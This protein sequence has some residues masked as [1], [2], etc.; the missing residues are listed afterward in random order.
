MA[1]K[2]RPD[3]IILDVMMPDMD[4]WQVL[5]TL[6]ADPLLNDI[7]VIMSSI[8]DHQNM[9]YALGAT[10]YLVKPVSRDQ[11][12]HILSRYEN[13]D[14]DKRLVMV[15]EDDLVIRELMAEMLKSA[16]WRV[17]KAENGQ[18]ALEHVEDKLPALI[19]LDLLMP[20]MDGYEFVEKLRE[21]PA[22]RNIPVVVLTSTHLTAEDHERLDGYVEK[23]VQ[24]EAYSRHQL[25]VQLHEMI[26]Q[27]TGSHNEKTPNIEDFFAKLDTELSAIDQ[28]PQGNKH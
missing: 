8:E 11:L 21:N 17:F 25:L 12:A 18:V 6:K 24:K 23:I 26:T 22:W 13:A 15:V 20:V 1:K 9:G 2:L 27:K 28:N 19:L 4:G 5:S 10:D 3:A 14:E 16:G 7:P